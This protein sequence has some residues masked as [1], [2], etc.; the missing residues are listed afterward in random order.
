MNILPLCAAVLAAVLTLGACTGGGGSAPIPGTDPGPPPS[1]DPSVTRLG[2]LLGRADAL[3]LTGLHMRWSLAAEGEATVED[4][5]VAAVACAGARCVGADGAATTA[6]DLYDPAA[7]VSPDAAEAVLGQRGGFDTVTTGGGFAVAGTVPGPAVTATPAVMGFGFWGAHGAAA[8]VLGTGPLAAE[9]DG[10][11]FSGDFAL[12]QAWAAGDATGTN[13]VGVGGATWTGIAEASPTGA[14]ERLQ[15]TA[16][17]TIADL[18]APRVGVAIDVPGHAIGAA[19]WTDLPLA[20]GR[21]G[22]GTPGID[23]LSGNFHG[24]GHEEAWGV[25]DT[26]DYLGAFGARKEQ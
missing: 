17:V 11:A 26:A 18:S 8:L 19:L 25:F 7:G 6:G 5:V 1:T 23:H 13:P 15:G 22:A 21:F 24:P 12:A 4:A 20:A 2:E 14:F 9:T 3:L 16:T 10:T